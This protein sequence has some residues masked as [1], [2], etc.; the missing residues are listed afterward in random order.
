MYPRWVLRLNLN[1]DNDPLCAAVR[2]QNLFIELKH[3][4]VHPN[5]RVE[6]AMVLYDREE[7]S[8]VAMICP[9]TLALIQ[10]PSTHDVPS[11]SNFI[12]LK[13]GHER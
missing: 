10:S 1:F 12:H 5:R 2:L 8:H 6:L 11:E 7:H 13:S 4:L 9:F 3:I